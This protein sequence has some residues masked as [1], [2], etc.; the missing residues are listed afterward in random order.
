MIGFA[1]PRGLLLLALLPLFVVAMGGL[2]RRRRR[3]VAAFPLLRDFVD[4]LPA[5]PRALLLRTRLQRAFLLLAV[6]CLA[7]SAGDVIVGAVD[8]K[9]VRAALLLDD[10]A[11]G[12]RGRAE[13]WGAAAGLVRGFR[14]DDRIL[15]VRS[16]GSFVTDGFQPPDVA[17]RAAE[18][19]APPA[20]RSD[21]EAGASSLAVVERFH[22]P[23][24]TAIVTPAPELW[25]P[26]IPPGRTASW[27]LIP[28]ERAPA[29]ANNALLNVE[30][31]PDLLQRGRFSLFCRVASFAP[32]GAT[33]PPLEVSVAIGDRTIATRSVAVAPGESRGMHFADL[34]AGEGLLSVRVAPDD[35]FPADNVFFSPFRTNPFLE[36]RLVS[37]ANPA[38]EAALRALPGLSLQT[39]PSGPGSAP[40]AVTVYDRSPPADGGGAAVLIAPPRG[41][42][43]LAVRGEV[44]TPRIIEADRAHPL[45]DGVSFAGL[46]IG[47][48]PQLVPGPSLKVV[49]RAD[50][51]PLVLAGTTAGGR[52]LA[53]I[54]F[55]PLEANWVYEPSFPILVANLVAWA[56]QE[57][58]GSRSAFLVGEFLPEDVASR[59]VAMTDPDGRA[60]AT[61]PAGWAHHRF[62]V[63]GRHRIRGRTPADSGDVVVNLLDEHLS[64]AA[65]T[66]GAAGVSAESLAAAMRPT[67]P[68][69]A[70]HPT[71]TAWLL[72]GVALLVAERLVAPPRAAG[73]L[74]S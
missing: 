42:P 27:R 56:A 48:L 21:P 33:I 66:G 49:A 34:A 6:A 69:P 30:L 45:L 63:P 70:R 19:P 52:R 67:L 17:A 64:R 20:S 40:P 43:G 32:P 38:L 10:A 25:T 72:L 58:G 14:A 36:A 47:R 8:D 46:H 61:P 68:R 2:L 35:P 53:V 23:D 41:T 4:A 71:A 59:T 44:S 73:R 54:A 9:P 60:I 31:L 24:L 37:D 11:G 28:V 16:D 39:G 5:V 65:A 7:L 22:R 50:G 13:L 57:P 29:A 1:E 51:Y 18:L 55:D 74:A 15:L 3:E 26:V 12:P 62:E